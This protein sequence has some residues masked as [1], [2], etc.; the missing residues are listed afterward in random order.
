MLQLGGVPLIIFHILDLNWGI[1]N[2]LGLIFLLFI[3]FKSRNLEL[4]DILNILLFVL[5]W[6]LRKLSFAQ[7]WN[8][9]RSFYALNFFFWYWLSNCTCILDHFDILTFILPGRKL[10]LNVRS[11]LSLRCF[12]RIVEHYLWALA[13][14]IGRNRWRRQLLRS[15][16]WEQV[17]SV[18]FRIRWLL[19]FWLFDCFWT[20]I[21]YW[22]FLLDFL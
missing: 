12:V 15:S 8:L 1:N 6:N 11:N 9:G 7:K 14:L 20:T 5:S 21:L 3:I 19:V 17:S 18:F 16:S 10:L 13:I 4:S 2:L 22:F